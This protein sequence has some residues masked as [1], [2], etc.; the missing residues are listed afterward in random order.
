M[1]P[2]HTP[3]LKR[4]NLWWEKNKFLIRQPIKTTSFKK[5]NSLDTFSCIDSATKQIVKTFASLSSYVW[6]KDSLLVSG[7][8]AATIQTPDKA[9]HKSL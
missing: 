7:G 2:E 9:P 6:R 5:S 1:T 4:V 8:F 3:L